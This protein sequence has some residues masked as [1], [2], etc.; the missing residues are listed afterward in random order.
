MFLFHLKSS[1][2][3]QD[4]KY[5][6]PAQR[7]L[8]VKILP[9][10]LSSQWI[11]QKYKK[12]LISQFKKQGKNSLNIPMQIAHSYYIAL[13]FP[14]FVQSRIRKYYY[15]FANLSV[16]KIACIK[17][18]LFFLSS[19]CLPK[20]IFFTINFVNTHSVYILSV[21]LEVVL[22]KTALQKI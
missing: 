6:G 11:T 4:I 9:P 14:R 16:S 8:F 18:M 7:I 12:L 1:F 13:P 15:N 5:L 19:S 2:S 21:S 3:S 22:F 17:N 10:P 20:M